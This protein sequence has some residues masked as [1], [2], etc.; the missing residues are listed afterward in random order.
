[1]TKHFDPLV[2]RKQTITHIDDT[3]MQSQTKGELFTIINEYHTLLRKAGLKAAPDKTFFFLKKVKFLRHVI[4]PDGIQPIAERVD[5][6]RNL[7]SPQSKRDVMK[8][9]GCLGFYS[10]Y[11]RNLHFYSQP[12][13]ELI[14]V[15]TPV[16]WTEEQETLFNSIR[17]KIHKDTVLAVHSTDYPIH[18]HVDSSNVGTCC[19]LIQQ[20]PE[21][22]RIIS[23]SSRDSCVFD[24]VE[25]KIS[26]LHQELCGIVS[27]LQTYEHYIIGSQFRNYFYCDHKPILYL[28][29]GEDNYRVVFYDIK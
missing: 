13:Y 22:E 7:K 17:E 24:K 28:G 12:F 9:L 19:F 4:S 29:D 8:V 14:K 10:C 15:S 26:P 21:G 23:F 27:A 25:Q 16:H 3:I 11:I 5:A 1:M 2:R 6:L 18:I 20:F